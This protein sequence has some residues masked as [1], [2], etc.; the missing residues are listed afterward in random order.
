[1]R[2]RISTRKT[3]SP[4]F[5][6]ISFFSA[7]S[8]VRYLWRRELPSAARACCCGAI[9]LVLFSVAPNKLSSFLW[10]WVSQLRAALLLARPTRQS[11]KQFVSPAG[12]LGYRLFAHHPS[13]IG[14][15]RACIDR[16]RKWL[17]TKTFI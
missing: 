6:S 2:I 5:W 12:L 10:T 16:L 11:I 8:W 7:S 4:T 13:Q 1:M 9:F 17:T 14:T 3:I 15:F